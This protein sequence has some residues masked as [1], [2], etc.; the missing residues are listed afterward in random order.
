ME[1]GS[2][3]SIT[4][5]SVIFF[6]KSKKNVTKLIS[7]MIDIKMGLNIKENLFKLFAYMCLKKLDIFSLVNFI[8]YDKKPLFFFANLSEYSACFSSSFKIS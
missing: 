1:L 2:I 3:F 4:L 6:F 7:I 8:L 5:S